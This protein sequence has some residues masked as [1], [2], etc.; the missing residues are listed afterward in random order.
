MASSESLTGKK[1]ASYEIKQKLG[2]G[3]Q[4]VVY[5]AWC[6]KL[7]EPVV[8][9]FLKDSHQQKTQIQQRFKREAK[10]QFQLRHPNIVR[11]LKLVEEENLLGIVMDKVEGTDLGEFL[12]RQTFPL[13]DTKIR[14]I[15]LPLLDAL[16]YAHEQGVVHRDIKPSNILLE[17][18]NGTYIPRVMDFGIAKVFEDSGLQTKT[19]TLL[20]TPHYIA[21]EQAASSKYV[22]HRVDIYAL[23]ITLYQMLSGHL[24][25]EGRD[26][27]Q[28]I[29]AHMM[30]DVPPFSAWEL[31]VDPHLEAAVRKS[32]AKLPEERFQTCAEFAS[33]LDTVLQKRGAEISHLLA[34][35]SSPLIPNPVPPLPTVDKEL[36]KDIPQIS[37][38]SELPSTTRSSKLPWVLLSLVVFVGLGY[39]ML[40]KPQKLSPQPPKQT[41]TATKQTVTATKQALPPSKTGNSLPSQSRTQPKTTPLPLPQEARPTPPPSKT[42]LHPKRTNPPKARL[43]S[44]TPK[45]FRCSPRKTQAC[46]KK[47]LPLQFISLGTQHPCNPTKFQKAIRYCAKRCGKN[48]YLLCRAFGKIRI[49][50]YPGAPKQPLSK[51]TLCKSLLHSRLFALSSLFKTS[52]TQLKKDC[53]N[54]F[55][56]RPR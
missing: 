48:A 55:L 15:F 53:N 13:S 51:N 26:F 46:L 10:L 50:P 19:N 18:K 24:P 11:A 2:E 27:L 54:G 36:T 41:V 25:F 42:E 40:P 33:A 32:L 30:E 28:L 21:P 37:A 16:D 52:P 22:D 7:Q 9:K 34:P 29:T 3:E 44:K 1:V 17:E 6:T 39:A 43:L 49:Q 12:E 14:A 56:G 5:E 4:A 8:I 35:P 23:G 45:N 20:G 47:M 31:D 38:P